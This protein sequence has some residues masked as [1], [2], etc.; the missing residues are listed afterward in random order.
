MIKLPI[1]IW[2]DIFKWLNVKSLSNLTCTNRFLKNLIEPNKWRFI[3]SF[4]KHSSSGI[5]IP[6]TKETFLNYQFYIDWTDIIIKCKSQGKVIPE[7][8]IKWIDTPYDIEMISYYQKFSDDLV[9]YYFNKVSWK[10]LL[11][12]QKVP[13]DLIDII[14]QTHYVGGIDWLNYSYWYIIWSKQD[15]NFDFIKKHEAEIQW[16]PI[17]T[18]KSAICFELIDLYHEKLIWPEITKHGINEHVIENHLDKMDAFSWRNVSE[19]T[20][21][22]NRFIEK[23]IDKLDF[24]RMFRFQDINETLL[25]NLIESFTDDEILMYQQPIAL[26]QRLSLQFLRRYKSH[27]PLRLLIRN[28]KVLRVDLVSVY[29]NDI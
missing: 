29:K 1:E 22:S 28:H 23:Y 12:N 25:F 4:L 18:N 26:N 17:S 15:I 7:H 8:V 9:R 3:D 21:L 13:L 20:K 14:I 6:S 27:L 5:Y 24:D 10:N 19:Y 2:I 16:N 11:S